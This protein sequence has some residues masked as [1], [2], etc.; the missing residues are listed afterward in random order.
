M[1]KHQEIDDGKTLKSVTAWP[2]ELYS[3]FLNQT[4]VKENASLL[5]NSYAVSLR[6]LGYLLMLIFS[7]VII[8]G[9]V[10]ALILIA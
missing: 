1:E 10:F 6:I 3:N 8:I 2:L 5:Q 7:P 9:F 4:T